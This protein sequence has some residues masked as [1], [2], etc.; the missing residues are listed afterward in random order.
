[1]TPR[2]QAAIVLLSS[3]F[4]MEPVMAGEETARVIL[5]YDQGQSNRARIILNE[6]RLA[7]EFEASLAPDR[8][9][10]GTIVQLTIELTCVGCS[11]QAENA[12]YGGHAW[13]GMQPF[14]FYSSSANGLYGRRE[15]DLSNIGY[16]AIIDGQRFRLCS[17]SG[18]A[19]QICEA[20]VP[21][22]FVKR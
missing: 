6:G 11:N 14:M 3:L 7:R 20:T 4:I 16:R 13:H 15:I 2:A 19:E 18:Q 22:T 1:V 5:H 17:P 9:V 8:D 21:L 10:S 12:M